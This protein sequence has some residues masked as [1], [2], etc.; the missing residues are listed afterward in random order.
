MAVWVVCR[1]QGVQGRSKTFNGLGICRHEKE[2]V[3]EL[4]VE[5]SVIWRRLRNDVRV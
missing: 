1:R 2:R 3:S 4:I 5:R